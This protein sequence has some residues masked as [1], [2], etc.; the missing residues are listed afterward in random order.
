MTTYAE[1]IEEAAEHYRTRIAT[2]WWPNANDAG[3]TT[4]LTGEG[5]VRTRCTVED[6]P[7]M[8]IYGEDV[9]HTWNLLSAVTI[10]TLRR[11]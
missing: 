5:A 6:G 4:W 8:L 2:G 7:I 3:Q 11:D 9:G 10:P 1:I